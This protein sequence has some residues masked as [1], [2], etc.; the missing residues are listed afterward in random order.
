ME[1][2]PVMPSNKGVLNEKQK[3]SRGGKKGKKRKYR[4]SRMGDWLLKHTCVFH[5]LLSFVLTREQVL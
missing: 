1:Y 3:E 2:W 4:S 5:L